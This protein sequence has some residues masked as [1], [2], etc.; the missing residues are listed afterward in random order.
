LDSIHSYAENNGAI[1][2]NI[3]TI[4][5]EA[6]DGYAIAVHGI[7]GSSYGICA[8]LAGD[9]AAELEVAAKNGDFEFVNK[10]NAAF[11]AHVQKLTGDI[12]SLYEAV[13]PDKKKR[14]KKKPDIAIL[15]ELYE[16][17]KRFDTEVIDEQI[18]KLT[19]YEYDTDGDLIDSLDK[20]AHQFKY[21]EIRDKLADLFKEGSS[22][23]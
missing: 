22:N 4:T 19:A 1:I 2:E 8:E 6:L 5:E 23:E 15:K 7:K 10:N 21:K 9:M 13:V 20:S 18:S 12:K 14:K 16:A 17:C 11:I 3:K